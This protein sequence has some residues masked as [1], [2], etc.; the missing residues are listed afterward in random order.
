MKDQGR[1]IL[2]PGRAPVILDKFCEEILGRAF[3]FG[4][5]N[6]FLEVLPGL[7]RRDLLYEQLRVDR[8]LQDIL[9]SLV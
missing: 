9:D 4:L 6:S 5:S 8:F 1:L 3:L 2:D 7:T